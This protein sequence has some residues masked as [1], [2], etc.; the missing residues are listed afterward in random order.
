MQLPSSSTNQNRLWK[1]KLNKFLRNTKGAVAVE[2]ALIA[3]PFFILLFG[4]IEIALLFMMTTTLDYGVT[5]ASRQIR[6][7]QIQAGSGLKKEFSDLVCGNLFN[8]LD[9]GSKLHIDVQR[10]NDF[11]ASDAGD[12]LPLNGDGT[13]NNNFQ[14]NPGEANEIVLVQ[15]YYEW[16]L[17]T[18][19]LSSGLS[20]M[21]EG[22]RLLHSTAVF[23][24][25][26]F[27][28]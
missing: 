18:P 28:S 5:Q 17:I 27:G 6:T 21:A 12:G 4:L 22:K 24:N 16:K 19:I 7:G 25:E 3:A 15:V 10:Y 13:L 20:N 1:R 11:V 14:Y 23:R 9:C 8:L 2:F 26:P